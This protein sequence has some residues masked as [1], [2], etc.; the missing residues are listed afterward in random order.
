MLFSRLEDLYRVLPV[1]VPIFSSL[2]FWGWNERM[3]PEELHRRIADMR[4]KGMG[5]APFVLEFAFDVDEVPDAPC[6]FAIE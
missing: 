1:S 3:E 2:S 5:G 4:D 6:R